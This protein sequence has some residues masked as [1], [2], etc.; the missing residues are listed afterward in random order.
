MDT[1]KITTKNVKTTTLAQ[2]KLI[3][4]IAHFIAPFEICEADKPEYLKEL[5]SVSM[6]KN[7][8]SLNE[9]IFESYNVKDLLN[10]TRLLKMYLK[11]HDTM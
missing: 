5:M 7:L 9:F 8:D 6:T 3:Y 4:K 1:K 2:A 11:L 10:D